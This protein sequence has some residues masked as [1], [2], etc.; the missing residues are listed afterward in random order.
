VSAE[1]NGTAVYLLPSLCNHACDPSAHAAW[2][3]GDA[4]LALSTRRECGAGEELRITYI[5]SSLPVAERQEQLHFAYGFACACDTCV[6]DLLDA[7]GG[8]T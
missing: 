1:G 2:P 5:D 4:T 7:H 8:A 6:D 3:H